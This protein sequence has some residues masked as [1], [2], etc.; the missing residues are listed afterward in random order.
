MGFRKLF[1]SAEFWVAIIFLAVLA[2]RLILAFQSEFFNYE[3]YYS[4]RQ[5]EN[6][7][8]SGLPLYNDPL[9]YAGK[10]HL[11]AP[12]HYYILAFF[13][14]FIK[15]DL[16]AKIIPN[17]FATMIVVLAYFISLKI[18]KSPKVSLLTSFIAGFVHNVF[19]H[20]QNQHR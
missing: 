2:V 13:S 19:R 12:L 18:T 1:R 20:Q 11:F 10:V 4:L 15:S 7:W 14:I 6:I 16:A 8:Q 9:S 3:A 17:I 5:L